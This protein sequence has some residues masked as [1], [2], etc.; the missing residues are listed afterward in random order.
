MNKKYTSCENKLTELI[1]KLHYIDGDY[2]D[3]CPWCNKVRLNLKC[4]NTVCRND[5]N[6]KII[7]K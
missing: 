4:R 6:K 3:K 1:T 7:V 5:T 2:Y